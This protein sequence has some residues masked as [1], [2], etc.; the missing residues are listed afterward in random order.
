MKNDPAVNNQQSALLVWRMLV[1]IWANGRNVALHHFAI[2]HVDG[3]LKK[4]D[5]TSP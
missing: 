5:P 3:S 1:C 2:S 4:A